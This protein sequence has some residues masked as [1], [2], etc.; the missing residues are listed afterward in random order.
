M[1]FKKFFALCAGC[2]LLSSC[3]AIDDI[4]KGELGQTIGEFQLKP[5]EPNTYWYNGLAYDYNEYEILITSWPCKARIMWSGKYVGRTPF[6]YKFTGTLD[7]DENLKLQAIPADETYSS[8]EAVFR[9]RT[10]LPRK[11][12]FD[13]RN[14]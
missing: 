14:K 3:A 2:L 6:V 4:Q 12:Y 13:F 9:S 8:Q 7:R 11:I 5:V 1:I 10:E